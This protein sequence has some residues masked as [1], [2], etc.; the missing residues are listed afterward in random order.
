MDVRPRYDLSLSIEHIGDNLC[1]RYPRGS[2]SFRQPNAQASFAKLLTR[3]FINDRKPI[4]F[5]I[6]LMARQAS[7]TRVLNGFTNQR[8]YPRFKMIN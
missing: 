2:G 7:A 4:I 6:R 8:L 5:G 1:Y 3:I